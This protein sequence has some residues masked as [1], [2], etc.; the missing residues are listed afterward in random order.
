MNPIDK[1][2][3]KL[4]LIF[5]IICLLLLFLIIKANAQTVNPCSSCELDIPIGSVLKIT[6]LK[7]SDKSTLERWVNDFINN[8]KVIKIDKSKFPESVTLYYIEEENN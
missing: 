5:L 1:E 7:A 2:L 3:I 4:V 8:H 6:T